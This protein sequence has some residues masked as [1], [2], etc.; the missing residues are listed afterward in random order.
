[1][2]QSFLDEIQDLKTDRARLLE[3]LHGLLSAN[4]LRPLIGRSEM[5]FADAI[6]AKIAAEEKARETLKTVQR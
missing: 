4:N 1:M 5:S 2:K 3:A 6:D